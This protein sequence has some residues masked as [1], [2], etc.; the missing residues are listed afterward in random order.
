MKIHLNVPIKQNI[1]E[2]KKKFNEKMEKLEENEDAQTV[3]DTILVLGL[4]IG[5][6]T[7]GYKIGVLKTQNDI[8]KQV[9]RIT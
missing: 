5:G 7:C 3:L 8:M 4:V 1:E 2:I 6:A 9:L